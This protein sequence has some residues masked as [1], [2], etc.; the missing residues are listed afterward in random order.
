MMPIHHEVSNYLSTKSFAYEELITLDKNNEAYNMTLPSQN[1][2]ISK[3]ISSRRGRR[4]TIPLEIRDEVRRLKKQYTERR[5]RA[6]I[7]DK[8]NALHNLAMKLIGEDPIKYS[9]MEK[10]DILGICYTVFEGISRIL[11]ERPEL[12][13]RL[14]KLTS[15]C[16]ET[17]DSRNSPQSTDTVSLQSNSPVSSTRSDYKDDNQENQLVYPLAT[18]IIPSQMKEINQNPSNTSYEHLIESSNFCTKMDTKLR[19]PIKMNTSESFSCSIQ[20]N[21]EK[22]DFLCNK[23]SKPHTFRL[24]LKYRWSQMK[25]QNALKVE[26]KN[27]YNSTSQQS[28]SCGISDRL[29]FEPNCPKFSDVDDLVSSQWSS[30]TDDQKENIRQIISEQNVWRPYLS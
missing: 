30:V 24:P 16:L 11:K 26:D 1:V 18:S 28:L 21:N 10:S 12:L 3:N 20:P 19:S 22:A 6:C 25:N 9:K 23:S 13:S 2:N 5:R 29:I 7:S 17:K 15:S 8:M 27:D 14:H 4:S